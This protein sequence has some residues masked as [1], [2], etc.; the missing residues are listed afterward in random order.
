MRFSKFTPFALLA[1]LCVVPVPAVAAPA[2]ACSVAEVFECTAIAGCQRVT[3]QQ[4]NLPPLVT[5]NVKEKRLF[6]GLFGG[7]GLFDPGDVYEDDSVLI[8]HGRK[9]LLTWTAVVAKDTGAL[10]GSISQL[11]RSF[12]QF[13]HCTPNQ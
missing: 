2:Y 6:S 12:A 8:L 7:E 10:S 9:G 5:L 1:A 4:A 3:A 11:G 13:G